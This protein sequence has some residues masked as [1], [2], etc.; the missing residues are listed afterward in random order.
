MLNLEELTLFLSV[1]RMKLT[2]IDGTHLYNDILVHMPR[3]NKFTFSINTQVVN[4][5]D[6]IDLQSNND[7]RHSFIKIGYQN[8]DS[9]A[10]VELLE[11]GAECHVYSLPYQFNTFSDLT[12]SFQGG[13]FDKVRN[14][15]MNDIRPFELEF[16]KII[17]QD[18]P[19]LQRLAVI[20]SE[21]QKNKQHSS[22]L[23]TFPHLDSLQIIF[24]HI[25]YVEQFLFQTNIRLPRLTQL[26]I[27]YEA[28]VLVT[29]NFTNDATRSICSQLRHI[30][31]HEPFVRPENFDSYFPSL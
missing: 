19:F 13:R 15:A 18:F 6:K 30:Y 27:E 12:N 3:L 24:A 4:L 1:V 16:F 9:Y 8:V 17:S 11:F 28:L 31:F 7:I 14:L 29:N 23:I 22:T 25:D 10:D 2:Y 26:T 5:G 20:N 21:P